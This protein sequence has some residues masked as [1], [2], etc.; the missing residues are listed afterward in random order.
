MMVLV[1]AA[2]TLGK[3]VAT[4]LEY[5]LRK[6]QQKEKSAATEARVMSNYSI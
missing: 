2:P 5:R 6:L 1:Q 3:K 4:V